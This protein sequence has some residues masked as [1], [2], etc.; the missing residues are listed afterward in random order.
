MAE[1][2]ALG[3]SEIGAVV[4]DKGYDADALLAYISSLGAQAVIPSKKN[5]KEQREIDEEL[6]RDRN[7]VERFIGRTGHYRRIAT[8]YDKSAVSHL[9]F[10]HV[11]CIMTWLL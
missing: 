9:L 10:L 1:V 6:Y 8:C 5:R 3:S 11:A 7:K 2:A 4:A